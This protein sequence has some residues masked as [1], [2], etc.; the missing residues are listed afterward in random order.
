MLLVLQSSST[1]LSRC[2]W[3]RIRVRVDHS[4]IVNILHKYWTLVCVLVS[5]ILVI[6]VDEVPIRWTGNFERVWVF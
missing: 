6:P 4:S 5:D 2:A 3:E 1:E